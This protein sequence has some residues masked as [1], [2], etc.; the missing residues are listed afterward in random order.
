MNGVSTMEALSLDGD[1]GA[2]GCWSV[3]AEAL[4]SG[5]TEESSS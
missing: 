5:E 3:A 4:G 1:G 2:D